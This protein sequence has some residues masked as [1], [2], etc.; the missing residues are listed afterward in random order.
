MRTQLEIHPSENMSISEMTDVMTIIQ[1]VTDR[2]AFATRAARFAANA[3]GKCVG[4]YHSV[5]NSIRL[6]R[7]FK[8]ANSSHTSMPISDYFRKLRLKIGNDVV[9]VPAVTGY[10][11]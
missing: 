9:M 2:S 8:E 4:K 6:N 5:G 7:R 1:V 11:F 3:G 10:Y